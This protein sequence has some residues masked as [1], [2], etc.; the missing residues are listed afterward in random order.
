MGLVE[1]PPGTVQRMKRI[2]SLPFLSLVVLGLVQ[3][4][5]VFLILAWVYGLMQM[6]IARAQGV[7]ITPQEGVRLV[8]EQGWSILQEAWG[9]LVEGDLPGLLG[10]LRGLFG[11]GAARLVACSW[12]GNAIGPA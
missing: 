12:G 3:F 1:K 10:S 6:E 7:E 2:R 8:M 9:R 4:A 5:L 11:G